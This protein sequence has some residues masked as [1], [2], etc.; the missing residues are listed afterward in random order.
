MRE[1]PD[2]LSAG[3][4]VVDEEEFRRL[5]GSIAVWR[6]GHALVLGNLAETVRYARRALDLLPE[7][8]HLGRGGAAA[9]LGLAAWASGDLEAA[10]RWCA[11][12][13]KN[14]HQVWLDGR[15]GPRQR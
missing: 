10:Q 11:W 14:V 13:V 1:R 7:D 3:M 15:L 12:L 5:P 2:A 4:V 8:D 9:L 6:A